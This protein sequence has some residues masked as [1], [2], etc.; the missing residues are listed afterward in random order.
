MKGALVGA[1]FAAGVFAIA[2]VWL[3]PKPSFSAR[4]RPYLDDGWTPQRRGLLVRL[5]GLVLR[6]LEAAGSSSASVRRRTVALGTIDV[7]GFRLRQLEWA[8]VGFGAGTALG[9]AAVRMGSPVL[10][11]FAMPVAGSACC[12]LAADWNLSNRLRHRS[13]AMTNELP[14]IA[15]LLA[16]AV[17]AG[18]S[19]RAALER[20][21]AIGSGALASEIG[22]A[23][24]AVR[25]GDRLPDALADMSDRCGN[26]AVARFVDALVTSLERGTAL[27]DVLRAQAADA[28]EHARREL[29]EE[30]GS[31]EIRM[32]LPVVF[33]IMP[34]TIVFALYPSV[35]ALTFVP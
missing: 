22:R 34:I 16:L 5:L 21:S 9:F 15:E 29:L 20:V 6:G 28:R 24:D 19:I 14:D 4:V 8:T 10:A 11:A 3:W 17:G 31:K 12:A 2:A 33:L 32:L 25:A 18:E 7:H 35:A 26:L 13:R 1:A 23:L 30:G 27:G